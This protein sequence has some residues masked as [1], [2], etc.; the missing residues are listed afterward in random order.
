MIN[1]NLRIENPWSDKFDAGY[2]WNG[3]LT[4]HKVWE[5]QAYRS[6]AILEAGLRTTIRTDH[7]GINLEFGLFSF[8][9]VAQIYDARHWNYD[10]QTWENYNGND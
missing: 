1:L 4:K 2:C 7:A 8:R 9:F 10:T 3:K 6:N 5:F